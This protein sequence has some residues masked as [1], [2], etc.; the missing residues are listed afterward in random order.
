[1]NEWEAQLRLVEPRKYSNGTNCETTG[2]GHRL[3]RCTTRR[4]PQ[5]V[6]TLPQTGGHNLRGLHILVERYRRRPRLGALG[7]RGSCFCKHF[8]APCDLPIGGPIE[9]LVLLALDDGGSDVARA[10]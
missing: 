5:R 7:D 3:L 6:G 1:M 9:R 10:P 2:R 8:V 4:P